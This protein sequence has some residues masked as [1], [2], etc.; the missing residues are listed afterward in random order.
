MNEDEKVWEWSFFVS[1]GF[2][3][4]GS[5]V[6]GLKSIY[7]YKTCVRSCTEISFE[8]LYSEKKSD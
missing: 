1:E 7:T 4:D 5:L 6:I 2:G 3:L 8:E